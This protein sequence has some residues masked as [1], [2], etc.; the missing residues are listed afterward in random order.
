MPVEGRIPRSVWVLGGVSLLMD[1]SSEMVQT[2]MPLYLVAGLGLSALAVG[3]IEGIGAFTAVLIKLWA[4]TLA[5][6]PS[7]RKRLML[8]GYGLAALS[9][10]ILPLAE[11]AAGAFSARFLD[12]IGKGLRG[13]PRDAMIAADTPAAIR[14]QAFGLRKSMDTLGGFFGPLLATLLL[15]ATAGQMQVVLWVAV[16]PAALAVA[17]LFFGIEPSADTTP[18]KPGKNLPTWASMSALGQGFWLVMAVVVVLTLARFSE[19]FLLLKAADSGI[20]LVWVPLILVLMHLVYSLVAYPVGVLSD[21]MGRMGLLLI[22][23]AFLFIAYLL[24]AGSDHWMTLLLAVVFWGLHMGFS[25]GILA[26][27]VADVAPESL[28][29]TA[30]ALFGLITGAAMLVGNLLAG[31]LWTFYGAAVPFQ[32]GAVTVLVA[33]LLLLLLKSRLSLLKTA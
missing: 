25:Q 12:R 15:L 1:V 23:L 17:L 5:D 33:L 21:R 14:G 7:W 16:I 18:A 6:R 32:V 24:L 31:G 2:L 11:S 19:A 9:R 3:L 29:G 26:T 28:R 30:F 22:S 8:A 10:P 27:L 4:G 20:S 13:A